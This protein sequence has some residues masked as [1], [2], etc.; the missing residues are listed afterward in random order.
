MNRKWILGFLLL[1]LIV[2]CFIGVAS[3]KFGQTERIGDDDWHNLPRVEMRE[4]NCDPEK[5]ITTGKLPLGFYSYPIGAPDCEEDWEIDVDHPSEEYSIGPNWR[6]PKLNLR[7]K[8][9]I[10]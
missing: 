8:T 5:L 7:Q 9:P 6:I 4:M 2:G 1:G 10:H 3:H